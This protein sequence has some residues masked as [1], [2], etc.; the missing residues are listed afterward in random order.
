MSAE[1]KPHFT[2]AEYLAF[3]EASSQKHDYYRGEIYAM[4]SGTEP[5]NLLAGN[6]YASLHAQLR[7]RE[8]RVY[9]SDQRVKVVA[10]GLHTYP[11]V[12]VVC[13]RPLFVP[14]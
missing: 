1:P 13:G 11:D 10:T 5:H 14:A 3:E 2:E 7:H 12:T 6:S 4:T 9:T 8:C